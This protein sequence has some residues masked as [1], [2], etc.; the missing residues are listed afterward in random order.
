MRRSRTRSAARTRWLPAASP[1]QQLLGPPGAAA[2]ARSHMGKGFARGRARLCWGASRAALGQ[3]GHGRL[4]DEAE[5]VERDARRRVQRIA[6]GASLHLQRYTREGSLRSLLN[7]SFDPPKFENRVTMSDA[8]NFFIYFWSNAS[9]GPIV[10]SSVP[11]PQ[12]L[13][14]LRAPNVRS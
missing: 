11:R 10:V 8:R 7:R 9:C 14:E 1:T 4:H 12:L 13:I 5:G 6:Q 3:H 2:P